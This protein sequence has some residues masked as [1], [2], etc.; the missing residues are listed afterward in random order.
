MIQF[1]QTS[2]QVCH[3]I[4][5]NQYKWKTIRNLMWMSKQSIKRQEFMHLQLYRDSQEQFSIKGI[6]SN[7]QKTEKFLLIT[8]PLRENKLWVRYTF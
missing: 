3:I 6:P 5:V 8:Q 2:E 1:K 7:F 4:W